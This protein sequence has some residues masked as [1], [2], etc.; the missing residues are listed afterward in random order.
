MSRSRQ[1]RACALESRMR[2]FRR[3]R[4]LMTSDACDGEFLALRH[5]SEVRAIDGRVTN[6]LA[7]NRAFHCA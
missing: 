7:I 6:L 5:D 1:R 4:C 2:F 3:V